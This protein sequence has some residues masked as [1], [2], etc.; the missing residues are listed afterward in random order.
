VTQVLDDAP[1]EGGPL[2]EEI[3][4][5]GPEPPEPPE[6]TECLVG[7]PSHTARIER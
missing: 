5:L 3:I 7:R 1:L 4:E 6:P 2:A